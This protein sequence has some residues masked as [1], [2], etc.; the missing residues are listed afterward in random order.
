MKVAVI[1]SR[2]FAD[3]G[4]VKDYLD[5]LNAMRD[6]TV[7]ISG[8]AQGAD[9]LG[10]RW[11]DENRVAKRVYEAKWRDLTHQD[12]LVKVNS[13]GYRYDARAGFRRNRDI[14]D[15]ADVILAFWNMSSPGTGDSIGYAKKTRKP[16]KIIRV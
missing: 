15:A 4:I 11:A 16:I 3:Y 9:S 14:V 12:T 2:G 1:G 10:E 5:R 13:S 6:I 8:G 7:I